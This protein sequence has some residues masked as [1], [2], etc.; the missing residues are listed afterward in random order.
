MELLQL[1]EAKYRFQS[2]LIDAKQNWGILEG[3]WWTGAVG[4]IQNRVRHCSFGCVQSYRQLSRL[5]FADIR[6]GTL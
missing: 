6:L 3:P 5:S 1:L 4:H 2:N